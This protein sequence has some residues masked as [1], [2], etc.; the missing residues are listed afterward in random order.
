MKIFVK[1]KPGSKKEEVRRIDG[2]H[3]EVNVK[4]PPREGKANRAILK[5]LAGHFGLPASGVEIVS[6]LRSKNKVF[7]ID[8]KTP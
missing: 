1:A 5:V 8:K 2:L 6:G 3:F 4:E 7:K